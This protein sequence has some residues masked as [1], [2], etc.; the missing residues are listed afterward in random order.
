MNLSNRLVS[1]KLADAMF[2][3]GLAGALAGCAGCEG[4]NCNN[5]MVPSDWFFRFRLCSRVATLFQL[6]KSNRWAISLIITVVS[7]LNWAASSTTSPT[8]LTPASSSAP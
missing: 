1:R 8:A 7:R 4:S 6:P 3:A 5:D 2:V